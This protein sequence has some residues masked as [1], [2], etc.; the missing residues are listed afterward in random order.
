M[1]AAKTDNIQKCFDI[2]DEINSESSICFNTEIFNALVEAGKELAALKSA[3]IANTSTNTGMAGEI[4]PQI[5]QMIVEDQ[6]NHLVR[7][8]LLTRPQCMQVRDM[9]VA[10]IAGKLRHA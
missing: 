10:I 8:K 9:F 4:S 1:S 5:C 6:L 2:L 3:V 7:E